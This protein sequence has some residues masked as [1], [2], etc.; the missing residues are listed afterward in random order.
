M[1]RLVMLL[2]TM[3]AMTVSTVDARVVV[4][5]TDLSGA[6]AGPPGPNA[7][8]GVGVL[9]LDVD[10]DGPNVRGAKA[11]IDVYL[12][13]LSPGTNVVGATVRKGP[14]GVN[15]PIRIDSGISP[16]NPVPVVGVASLFT[17]RDLFVT[18]TDA[19]GLT[20][21]PD[22]FYV[23]VLTAVPAAPGQ[24]LAARGQLRFV[25][26][27]QFALPFPGLVGSLYTNQSTYVANERFIARAAVGNYEVPR[28]ADIFVGFIQTPAESIARCPTAND[29]A[30]Q[31]RGPGGTTSIECQSNLLKPGNRAIPLL[32]SVTIPVHGLE[33][34][35][36]IDEPMTLGPGD[37]G[38][39]VCASTPGAVQIGIPSISRCIIAAF[40]VLQ[41]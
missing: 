24:T 32:T 14:P 13:G 3:M 8:L 12:A 4:L 35:M 16:A 10:A 2:A 39:F 40:R 6:N 22:H 29:R 1:K 23:E 19:L 20:G 17:R 11:A 37:R 36:V 33:V 5:Q 18:S 38:A 30:L 34:M 26:P 25:D 41:F 21:T 15:G 31:F 9:Y 7:M 28:Q 27:F